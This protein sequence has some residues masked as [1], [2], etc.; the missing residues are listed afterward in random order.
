MSI[1]D[2]WD[3]QV[4]GVALAQD[5]ME[6]ASNDRGEREEVPHGTY[7]VRIDK[8]ELRESK[9]GDPMFT[10]WFRVLEGAHKNSLIFMNQV[11][12]RGFQIHIVNEFM[13]SLQTGVEVG[14]DGSYAHYNDTVMD[15]HEAVDGKLEFALEYGQTDKG[16]DTFK[17]AEVFE[18]A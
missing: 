14:F 9:K 8:M 18:T 3:E 15:I 16:Y 4:D 1:F 6:A 2:K 13:R 12:T 17:V 7:E 11:I 10:C 5:V